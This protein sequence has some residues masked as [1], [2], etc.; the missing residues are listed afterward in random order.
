MQKQ[1]AHQEHGHELSKL[2]KKLKNLGIRI[3]NT[4]NTDQK[5]TL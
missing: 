3:Q 5:S 2:S 4:K 1:Q